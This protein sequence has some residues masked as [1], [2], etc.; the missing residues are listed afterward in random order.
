M[1]VTPI[2]I[3]NDIIYNLENTYQNIQNF[4]QQLSSGKRINQPSD[5]PAGTAFSLDMQA[6]SDWNKQYQSS[7]QSAQSWLQTTTSALQQLS[8]VAMRARTLAV[9]AAND[10]NTPS[11]RAATSQEIAQLQQQAVQIGNTQYEN[12]SIFA[13]AQVTTTP[14]NTQGG[15]AGDTGAIMHQIGPGYDMQVNAN[16]TS[17]FTGT[18]G[19]FTVLNTV[20][21][22][23]NTGNAFTPTQNTGSETL[24]LTGTYTGAAANYTVQVTGVTAGK[25][26]SIQYSTTGGAPWTTVAAS[27]SPPTF[28]L[29]SG[30]TASFTNGALTPTVG[31]QF[32][33]V[34]PGPGSAVNF[35]TQAS[36]NIGTEQVA[37]TSPSTLAGNPTITVRASQ[38]DVNNN[39]IGVQVSTDGG[40]TFSPTILANEVKSAA[41]TMSFDGSAYTGAPASYLVRVASVGSSGQP[42][43]IVTST[44]NGATWSA[45]VTGVGTPPTFTVATGLT[46]NFNAGTAQVN[47][48]FSFNATAGGVGQNVAGITALPYPTTTTF[49]GDNGLAL[50]WAQ[51]SVNPGQVVTNNDTFTYTPATTGLGSDLSAIDAVISQLA[52]QEAQFGAKTNAVQ[53]NIT[54][55]Q[56]VETTNQHS[57]SQVEDADIAAVSTQMATANTVYQAAL[58]V[59]ARSIEPTLVEFLK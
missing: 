48:Q 13:G 57:L 44:D 20:Y 40:M 52:G 35:T 4:D 23:M 50:S 24:S 16:P 49:A 28:A 59:D 30:M 17:I 53:A 19:I 47:D 33:I 2:T 5:D 54:Q 51:S 46:L 31:D 27:G 41:E 34:A 55:L 11:D 14:F 39:V 21:Q 43:T 15:Y 45:P 12:L 38:L 36:K 25:I 9:Q 22:H 6:S 1:R 42:A 26:A 18:G 10:S 32:T 58:A 56:T 8:D 37:L 7:S 3:A 29:P